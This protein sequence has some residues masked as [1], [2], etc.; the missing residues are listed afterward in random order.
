MP[1]RKS[2]KNWG[3]P[4]SQ[5]INW[6]KTAVWT[7][8]S[9]VEIWCFVL[10]C[11]FSLHMVWLDCIF[12]LCPELEMGNQIRYEW[13]YG[14]ILFFTDLWI[15]WR[16]KHHISKPI[17]C[18]FSMDKKSLW[19]EVWFALTSQLV[20]CLKQIKK[21]CAVNCRFLDNFMGWGIWGTN[22]TFPQEL[23]LEVQDT[24]CNW[25]YVG[26]WP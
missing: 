14:R 26:L 9:S 17:W 24:G 12:T 8:S 5:E 25:L 22:A 11:T 4:K 23:Y 19:F 3:N 2:E 1:L 15:C 16:Y 21:R 18:K 20:A 13:L 6:S 7:R 10:G